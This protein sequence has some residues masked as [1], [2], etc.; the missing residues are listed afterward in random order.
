MRIIQTSTI[1]DPR[2]DLRSDDDRDW[3]YNGLDCCVTLEILHHLRPLL[4]NQTRATYEFSKSLQ[5]P[6]LDMS[7]T[8]LRVDLERRDATLKKYQEQLTAIGGQLDEIIRDGIGLDITMPKGAA[9]WRSPAKLK[10]LFY[11]VLGCKEIRKRNVHN[12]MVPTVNREALERLQDYY[13]AMP[14]VIR[15]LALRDIDKKRQFLETSLDLDNR[16]RCNFNIAGTNTGRLASSLSDFGT[17]TNLQ[18]VDRDLRSVFIADPGMKFA[19]IDLEQADARNVGAICW[20]LFVEELGEKDAGAYLNA[21]ESGDLHTT[22][23]SMAWTD[24]PWTGNRKLDRAIADQPAY[25]NLS[26][27]DLAKKLGHGTNYYGTP[28]TM[29][30]HTKVAIDAIKLFQAKYFAAFPAIKKWHQWV[31][32]QLKTT[33]EISTLYGRS[34]LFFGNPMEQSTLREA[35]AYAPQSMTADEINLGLLA[36]WRANICRVLVQ[37]H[38]SILIQYPEELEDEVVPQAIKLLKAPITL[39]RGREFYVPADCKTGWNWGDIQYDKAGNVVG[40]PE[41]LQK[42]KGGDTRKREVRQTFHASKF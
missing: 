33:Q 12:K 39:A 16:I 35:I 27:R 15:L 5:A 17:G 29:A 40:N 26:F 3:V 11:S 38:D 28:P 41:G 21:C 7:M 8:G 34:R 24:Q 20:N 19:N 37:V 31:E 42:Y 18:N 25:R 32:M 36:V 2:R 1:L 13:F 10:H 22:V 14:I 6:I 23:C 9:Y 4:D 30:K